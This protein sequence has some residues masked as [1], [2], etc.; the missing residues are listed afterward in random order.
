MKEK[1]SKTAVIYTRVSSEAQVDGTSLDTQAE[2]CR[3]CAARLGL[4]VVSEHEDA[5]KSAKSTVGR[6]ALAAAV[7]AA[8]TARAALIVYK[9]DRLSRNLGDGYD[10]RDMLLA[11]GCRI[12]SATEG[13]ASASPVSKAL[14]AMMMAFSELDNDMRAERCR[15]GMCA[16]AKAGFWLSNPPVGFKLGKHPSGG[17]ILVPDGDQS[18]ILRTA[19]LDFISGRIDK[20]GLI[21]R[22]KDA[23]HP[24]STID[25]IIRSPVYGGIIRNRLTDGEDVTAAFPGLITAD[26]FY[27][28]EA[29]LKLKKRVQL[30]DNPAFPYTGI[31]HCSVCGQPVRSGFSKSKGKSFGYYFC[32]EA[33]HPSARR[34][35][36]HAQIEAMLSDLGKIASF[37]E[38][39]KGAVNDLD[40][41]DPD[42]AERARRQRAVSRIEPQLA[43]LRSALLE[44]VFSAEEYAAEKDRLTSELAEHRV[45]L[46]SHDASSDHRS[47]CIDILIGVFTNPA[48]LIEGLTVA[49]TKD[50]VRIVFGKLTLTPEKKI[51]PAQDSVYTILTSA[52]AGSFPDGAPGGD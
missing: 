5:G 49:Q 35:D 8:I 45:W 38:L 29:K 48:E 25:R 10:L 46:E 26:Q 21:K 6:D 27:V 37:L 51:E 17:T 20:S 22:L 36:I 40:L 31:I 9:F 12:I 43:R 2:A 7:D 28:M 19:F 18:V 50:L 13:E 34:D 1:T 42:R 44:G 30:K 16:R 39:L 4:V 11:K 32:K 52:N 23:G 24:G 15:T 41:Q 14:Y 47:E 3:A 33:K